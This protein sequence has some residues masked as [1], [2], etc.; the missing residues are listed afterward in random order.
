LVLKHETPDDLIA[1]VI[2]GGSERIGVLWES[3]VLPRAGQVVDHGIV[4]VER[5]GDEWLVFMRDLSDALI[6]ETRT[7]SRPEHRRMR[8]TGAHDTFRGNR[9]RHC[10]RSPLGSDAA[11]AAVTALATTATSSR[12]SCWGWERAGCRPV[13]VRARCSP[14]TTRPR[15]SPQ[16]ATHETTLTHGDRASPT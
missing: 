3:G 2:P 14:C 4:A 7:I 15:R 16:L 10:A 13:D 11:P 12:R 1:L 9:S 8:E 6:V 5:D